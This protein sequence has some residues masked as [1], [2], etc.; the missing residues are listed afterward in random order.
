MS[1][2]VSSPTS[3]RG[4]G[5][6]IPDTSATS[7]SKCGFQLWTPLFASNTV[8]IALYDDAR[9][10]GRLL[11]SLNDHYEHL[12]EVPEAV[13]ARLMSSTQSAVRCM[14]LVLGVERVNM[15]ILGNREPHVHAHLVPRYPQHEPLPDRAPWEDPR[16]RERLDPVERKRLIMKLSQ[17]LS[18]QTGLS[19]IRQEHF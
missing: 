1:R 15:A 9:F 8:T 10:P 17:A 2:S 12:D 3:V 7:C 5:T 13:I 14:K 18:V 4:I 19:E 6:A 11:V 16:P